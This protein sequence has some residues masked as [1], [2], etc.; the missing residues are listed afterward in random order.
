MGVV[1]QAR[2]TLMDRQ[3]VIKVINKSLLDQPNSLER[4][5]REVEAAA[6]LAHPNIVTAYDAE[7]AGELHMLVME[8]VPGQ[9]LA[10]VLQ[11]KDP[12]PVQHACVYVRQAAL[13]LQH[14]HEQ[15]MVHRDIKPHN[16]MLTPKGQVKILDFGLAKVASEH[17]SGMGLTA[18]NAY[19]G[20]PDYSAP[21]QATD[22]RSADIRA[23]IYSLGCT[24]YCLLAGKPPFH[25]KTAVQTIVAHLEKEPPLLPELRPDVPAALWAVVARMLAKDPAQRYQKP[26]EVAQALAPFCKPAGRATAGTAPAM[27]CAAAG[28]T[29]A[30]SPSSSVLRSPQAVLESPTSAAGSPFAD[31]DADVQPRKSP[32]PAAAPSGWLWWMAGGAMVASVGLLLLG[33]VCAGA[34]LLWGRGSNGR[35]SRDAALLSRSTVPADQ[36]SGKEGPIPNALGMKFV[37]VPHGSFWM[38]DR[39]S[40]KQVEIA[41]DFYL[42]VFPVTQEQWQAVMDSNPSWFSRSGGGADMVKAFAD[43]DLKQ[44]P[45]EQVSWDDVQEFVKRL[46]AREKSTGF[47][48]RL[49]TEAEWEYACRGGATSQA[50]CAFD[51]YFAQPTNDL[52]SEQANFDG[53]NPAGRAPK[54]KCLFRTSKVGSYQPNRLG[55]YDMHGNVWEWCEDHVGA[56]G[57]ARVDRGGCWRSYGSPCRASSRYVLEPPDRGFDLGF[58]LAAVPS[59][60]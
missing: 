22:A 17:G 36:S 32:K 2:Q 38:G 46:N 57:S 37:Q 26:A 23:D 21:E 41:R 29:A 44:F 15:G 33:G 24:L 13:G 10:E 19:M 43:A 31:L 1:Y 39:G 25:E 3:V 8:F 55:I 20:T 40:Q 4:F 51:F 12:L 27:A 52:S 30:M 6:K 59:G 50:D 58:R 16:L 11:K 5:R 14:A 60:Q 49:P 56:E 48:Y 9:S 35:D 28:P 34:F 45:V 7:Q 53:T 42:G 54:G 18:L 47:L